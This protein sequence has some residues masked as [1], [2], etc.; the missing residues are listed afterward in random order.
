MSYQ[1][2]PHAIRVETFDKPLKEM[3]TGKGVMSETI[4]APRDEPFYS[5]FVSNGGVKL[6]GATGAY[7]V[8]TWD[9]LTLGLKEL[10]PAFGTNSH[11]SLAS[12]HR[13]MMYAV[14]TEIGMR[15]LDDA[16]TAD[17]LADGSVIFVAAGN[18]RIIG[19]RQLPAFI[20]HGDLFPMFCELPVAARDI[21]F[22]NVHGDEIVVTM[23]NDDVTFIQYQIDGS[24]VHMK[25]VGTILGTDRNIAQF[26]GK[27]GDSGLV[28]VVTGRTADSV[29]F[30]IEHAS[31]PRHFRIA[32]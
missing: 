25:I 1:P 29:I 23:K 14:A 13:P 21:A 7:G 8:S 16:I 4:I 32:S 20:K 2:V 31:D 10:A 30:Q 17:L 28:A 19:R 12:P 26:F 5:G 15:V 11:I 27:I 3:I 22:L 24:N 6:A 18:L 9:V